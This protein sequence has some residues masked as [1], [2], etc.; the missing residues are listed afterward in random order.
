M[1]HLLVAP[2]VVSGPAVLRPGPGPRIFPR[3]VGGFSRSGSGWWG[4]EVGVVEV[5]PASEGV[6]VITE[7]G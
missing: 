3:V 2:C 7:R 6:R 4:G 1:E 5:V